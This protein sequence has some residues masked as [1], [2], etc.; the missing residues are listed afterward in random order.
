MEDFLEQMG[1][2]LSILIIAAITFV[3]AIST[4]RAQR[5]TREAISRGYATYDS[6]GEFTWR[7]KQ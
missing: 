2:T 6:N 7:E 4:D 1:A 3:A 5:L